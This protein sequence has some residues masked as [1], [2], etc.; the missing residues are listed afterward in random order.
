[1]QDVVY[2]YSVFLDDIPRLKVFKNENLPALDELSDA[3]RKL[4]STFKDPNVVIEEGK[5]Y[6][7]K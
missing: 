4:D 6:V 7:A 2:K 3:L 5:I 1:M